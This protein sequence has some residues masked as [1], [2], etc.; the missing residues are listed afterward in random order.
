[1]RAEDKC[2]GDLAVRS[3]LDDE[4]G[5][6]LFGRRERVARCG[7]PTDPTQLRPRPTLPGPGTE[8]LEDRH[9]GLDCL[10]GR[11]LLFRSTFEQTAPEQGSPSLEGSRSRM[12]SESFVKRSPSLI[13]V[14][15]GGGQ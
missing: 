2:G 8:F 5:D 7:S 15:V 1:M 4:F 14:A 6:A 11:A 10:P 3:S 9:R 13:E 12:F